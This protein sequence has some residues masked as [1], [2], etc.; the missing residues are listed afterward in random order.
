MTY[1]FIEK[2]LKRIEKEYTD[3]VC[4]AE[5]TRVNNYFNIHSVSIDV[6]QHV[7]EYPINCVVIKSKRKNHFGQ[8]QKKLNQ[9]LNEDNTKLILEY[10]TPYE[11]IN[12]CIDIHYDPFYYPFERAPV[13]K[14]IQG[15]SSVAELIESHNKELSAGWSPA[16]YFRSD[17]IYFMNK[18]CQLLE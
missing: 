1:R 14:L 10:L 7:E 8:V 18:F 6:Y 17:L 3:L 16:I 12:V 13:W 4:E 5:G 15:D 2:R 9:L 11:R